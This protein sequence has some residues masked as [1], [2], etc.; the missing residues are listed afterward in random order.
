MADARSLL[1]KAREKF[2]LQQITNAGKP[3]WVNVPVAAQEASEIPQLSGRNDLRSI[4]YTPATTVNVVQPNL[5]DKS[6]AAH[7]ATHAFQNTRNDQ[8]QNLMQ[9]M[10]PQTASLKN[11][12]YGGVNGLLAN[13]QRSIASY[14]PEQQAEMVEDL[15]AAQGKLND[16]MMPAQ[17]AAW[18][19]TKAALER[20][21][22]QLAAVP[23]K[24]VS[25]A[26]NIDHYLNQRGFGDPLARLMGLI[27]PPTMNTAPQPVP[28]APSVALGYANRSKLVR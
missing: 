18:D 16:H 27:S 17:L 6:I 15:T 5:Y 20:P 25:I 22:R 2:A 8:F 24:D 28:D 3:N 21:I 19:R 14:S 10:A 13:P 11:Y 26:G 12:D 7:E 9:L 23:A 1:Q 4:A